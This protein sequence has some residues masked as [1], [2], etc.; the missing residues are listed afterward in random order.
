M[1]C[2][3]NNI[4]GHNKSDTCTDIPEKKYSKSVL[5]RWKIRRPYCY[6]KEILSSYKSLVETSHSRKHPPKED[7]GIGNDNDGKNNGNN[8]NDNYSTHTQ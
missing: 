5:K 8:D 3:K 4:P 2:D 7:D 6:E 1:H